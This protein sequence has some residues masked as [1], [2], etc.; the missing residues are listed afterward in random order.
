MAEEG[1]EFVVE[2]KSFK[3]LFFLGFLLVVLALELYV[4][5]TSSIA[6]GDEGFHLSTAR[7][8]GQNLVYPKYTPLLGS[9]I[10]HDNFN[11]PILW[12]ITE[13]F[14]YM[15]GGI[16]ELI[17]K[18]LTPFAAFLTGLAIYSLG[19]KLFSE[20][21]AIFA[22]ILS[23]TIP[24][25]VTYSVL[26]YV[27][28]PLVLFF[29]IGLLTFLLAIK[30]EHKKYFLM[31]AVFTTLA[32]LTDI[33]GFF[34]PIFFFL[35]ALYE[36]SRKL[37]AHGFWELVKKYYILFL[38]PLIFVS[39]W[40]IRNVALYYVSGC[41]S[42]RAVIQGSCTLPNTYVPTYSFAGRT[43]TVG[44]ETGVLQL[45][46]L[47]Y[48]QFAYGFTSSNAVLSL[49][50]VALI[51]FSFVAG[52]YLLYR[53]R[54]KVDISLIILT[55]IFAI[56][57]FEI[58][59]LVQGRAEDTARYFLT[60]VPL[61]GL[62]CGEYFSFLSNGIVSFFKRKSSSIILISALTLFLI[63][64]AYAFYSLSL[65]F[66]V[67]AVIFLVVL[68]TVFLI[69]GEQR[70]LSILLIVAAFIIFFAFVNMQQ[71]AT[72][73]ISVKRFSPLFF[74]ACNWV[75]QNTPANA[76]LLSLQTYPTLYNC[77]RQAV[78]VI[79][80]N[81]DII[82]SDNI[83]LVK[84][85]LD[86]NG[87]NYIFVQKFSLSDQNYSQSY[88]ISFVDFLNQNNQTFENVYENGV[89]VNT[90]IQQGG[91]DGTIVYKVL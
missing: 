49:L 72:T 82:L 4:T 46:I 44:T 9:A 19:K 26:F 81:P 32:I 40:V 61:I 37:S 71:K 48:L 51:P 21:A 86:A 53:R 75:Q 43:A 17:I 3:K 66:L 84:D 2:V 27:T 52:F 89:D 22:S 18:F 45:G 38:I 68:S 23:V 30:T 64:S 6:F 14:F 60:A 57:F 10:F 5:F 1:N 55:V 78:W 70:E 42:F 80:D 91:C 79:P 69:K 56:A 31:S 11:R 20:N 33:A 77:N 34:L 59:G 58:G 47:S 24:S 76:S 39:P 12:D 8:I 16:A 36:L 67:F 25:F 29:S 63:F 7:A 15:F 28:V 90:C 74:Q 65:I 85:R 41:T 83:T 87:I 35:F 13:A 54:E 73:M 88:P 62:V 50:G